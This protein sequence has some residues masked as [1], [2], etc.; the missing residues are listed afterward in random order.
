M[1]GPGGMR[2]TCLVGLPD[3]EVGA[4]LAVARLRKAGM[5]VVKTTAL[6]GCILVPLAWEK[7]MGFVDS[8]G[9]LMLSSNFLNWSLLSMTLSDED[10]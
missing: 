4:G 6:K 5:K 8:S 9:R 1:P 3:A 10:F 7:Y 2:V